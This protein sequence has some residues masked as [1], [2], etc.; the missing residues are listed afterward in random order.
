MHALNGIDLRRRVDNHA[1]ALALGHG[2]HIGQL[3]YARHYFPARIVENAGGIGANRG[4]QLC[5]GRAIFIAHLD[6]FP[7]RHGDTAVVVITLAL[8]Q[9]DFICHPAGI[10]QATNLGAI[11]A[12]NK[13]GNPLD[14]RRKTA[15]GDHCALGPDHI[16]DGAAGF[17]N[18]LF[19]GGIPRIGRFHRSLYGGGE[20]RTAQQSNV[21]HG[22]DHPFDPKIGINIGRRSSG[23]GF[24]SVDVMV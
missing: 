4:F 5:N 13:T 3:E 24:S 2:D 6:H 1:C 17:V 20:H 19:Q 7:A 21:A 22:I 23:H 15:G 14:Q 12:G 11:I 18:D 10:G 8:L 16:G 9:Q